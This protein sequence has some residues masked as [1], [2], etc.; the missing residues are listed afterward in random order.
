MKRDD[1]NHSDPQE[2]SAKGKSRRNLLAG[3]GGLMAGFALVSA[4]LGAQ[5][6]QAAATE[7]ADAAAA[8]ASEADVKQFI[9]LSRL[10][11]G[12]QN[13]DTAVGQRL[14]TAMSAHDAKFSAQVAELNAYVSSHQIADV[15]ALDASLKDQPLHGTMMSIIS[16]WYLGVI[17]PGH[18]ATVYAYERA[19]MYQIPR[20][21]MIVPTYALHGPDYWV[22][23]PPPVDRLPV[24]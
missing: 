20:D 23:E 1:Q 3:S 6:I 9:A 14:Y 16:A 10:L 12:H 4:G 18:H 13:L 24:F 7:A 17:E 15:E 22:A 19:L 21:G 2:L 5:K 11:T 8:P